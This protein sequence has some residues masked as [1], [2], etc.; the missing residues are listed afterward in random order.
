MQSLD[1]NQL[2]R[3]SYCRSNHPQFAD[4]LF[5]L[6]MDQRLRRIRGSLVGVGMN[7]DQNRTGARSNC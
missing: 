5:N 2:E 4:K 3:P 1:G 7:L 6:V